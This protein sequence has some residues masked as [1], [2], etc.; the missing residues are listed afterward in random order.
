[1]DTGANEIKESTFSAGV[2]R[3]HCITSYVGCWKKKCCPCHL[4][5]KIKEWLSNLLLLL[6]I[7]ELLEIVLE[8]GCFP[9]DHNFRLKCLDDV[10]EFPK[11]M[12]VNTI[13][14]ENFPMKAPFPFDFDH[15]ISR[16]FGQDSGIAELQQL[17]DSLERSLEAKTWT[18]VENSASQTH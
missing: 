16:N 5:Q 7:F 1:M 8:T 3:S 15:G 10:S 11:E 4:D 2:P 12:I 13:I 14:F 6:Y 18:N 9:F 17:S